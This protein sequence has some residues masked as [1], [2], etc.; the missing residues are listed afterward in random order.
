MMTKKEQEKTRQTQGAVTGIDER[1]ERAG[2]R[3]N[4]KFIL[5]SIYWVFHKKYIVI[6]CV[7]TKFF[8]INAP[9]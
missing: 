9:Y 6:L 2:N 4:I 1:K 7:F 3:L 8:F 5:F